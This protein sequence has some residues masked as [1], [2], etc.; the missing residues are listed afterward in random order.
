MPLFC[1]HTYNRSCDTNTHIHNH[2]LTVIVWPG[3]MVT[4]L[5]NLKA[6]ISR[7]LMDCWILQPFNSSGWSPVFTTLTKY[8]LESTEHTFNPP[9]ALDDVIWCHTMYTTAWGTAPLM[10]SNLHSYTY[11]EDILPVPAKVLDHNLFVP[12]TWSTLSANDNC[13]LFFT[14]EAV[15][16]PIGGREVD[17]GILVLKGLVM[18]SIEYSCNLFIAINC[19]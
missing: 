7:S 4:P 14:E 12:S 3:S 5:G 18:D 10:I 8:P 13:L 15:S 19:L 6:A 2:L 11:N 1:D 9:L 17:W 16:S